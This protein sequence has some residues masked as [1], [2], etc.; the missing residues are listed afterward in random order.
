MIVNVDHLCLIQWNIPFL[1][2]YSD[3]RHR[4]FV[5]P[6]GGLVGRLLRRRGPLNPIGA[7]AFESSLCKLPCGKEKTAVVCHMEHSDKRQTPGITW[8]SH[9]FVDQYRDARV[10]LR[11]QL[12]VSART[13]NG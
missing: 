7:V 12:C 8:R 11:H 1:P 10:D 6:G 3:N 13:K 2:R 9:G 5:A 4:L